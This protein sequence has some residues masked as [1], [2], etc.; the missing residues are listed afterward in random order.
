LQDVNG[1]EVLVSLGS[2]D[3]SALTFAIE[4]PAD[5]EGIAM[6]VQAPDGRMLDAAALPGSG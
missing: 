5:G 3:G 2:W 4:P 6:L 1:V